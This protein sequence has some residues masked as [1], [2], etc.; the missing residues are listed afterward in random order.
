MKNLILISLLVLS[1]SL[2]SQTFQGKQE[3]IDIILSNIKDFSMAVMSSDYQAIGEAYTKDAKIFPNNSDIIRGR[4]AIT[5]YWEL[6]QGVTINYH[7]ISPEELRVLD[8][9]AYDYG[10]YEG[11]T[12]RPD[13][14]EIDWRGKYVIVWK[15]IG[16]EWKIY[17]D[18]WNR[19]NGQ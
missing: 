13:G 17:L 12:R 10:Y 7:N 2:A 16:T 14:T 15:K 19:V 5:K 18:I 3:D 1:H 4:D 8:E 9:D 6:P 11:T